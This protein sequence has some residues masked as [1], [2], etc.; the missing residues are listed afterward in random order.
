M[1]VSILGCRRPQRGFGNVLFLPFF[2]LLGPTGPIFT[3]AGGGLG[4]LIE[5]VSHGYY[6]EPFLSSWDTS[7]G[8]YGLKGDIDQKKVENFFVAMTSG[9][10][11][12]CW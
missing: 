6:L 9:N 12:F 3:T 1:K 11:S 5:D 4:V 7:L 8:T 2:G 10:G